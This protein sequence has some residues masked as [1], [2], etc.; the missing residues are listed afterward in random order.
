MSTVVDDDCVG[1]RCGTPNLL[2]VRETEARPQ[3]SES[4]CGEGW[5][6]SQSVVTAVS[7]PALLPPP[8]TPDSSLGGPTAY[9][10][11]TPSSVWALAGLALM[12]MLSEGFA[13]DWS[14]RGH[15]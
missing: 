15:A 10:R 3:V 9:R 12:L 1:L 2:A 6:A 11:K 14:A 4:G 7:A 5:S 8:R 13:N